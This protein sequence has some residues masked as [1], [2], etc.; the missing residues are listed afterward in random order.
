MYSTCAWDS[1]YQ[2]W[3]CFDGWSLK[4]SAELLLVTTEI[5]FKINKWLSLYPSKPN[6]LTQLESGACTEC[7]LNSI[8]QSNGASCVD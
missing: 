2:I 1:T 7:T 8:D 3:G 5:H 6:G 4:L